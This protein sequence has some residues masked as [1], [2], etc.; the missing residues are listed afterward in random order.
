[1]WSS[2]TVELSSHCELNSTVPH[3]QM[4]LIVFVSSSHTGILKCNYN[5]TLYLVRRSPVLYRWFLVYCSYYNYQHIH[6]T[7]L[8]YNISQYVHSVLYH[9]LILTVHQC[10][11]YIH[12]MEYLYNVWVHYY[13]AQINN[14]NSCISQCS[15]QVH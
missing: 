12:P 8:D 2:H 4:H 1:M 13:P 7:T 9:Q 6:H 5:T 10:S 14:F 15:I 3:A 11:W